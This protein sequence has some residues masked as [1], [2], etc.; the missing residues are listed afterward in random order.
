M[1]YTM[2]F[3]LFA[4][5]CSHKTERKLAS[6]N[7]LECPTGKKKSFYLEQVDGLLDDIRRTSWL[8]GKTKKAL[9][10]KKNGHSLKDGT[11]VYQLE[12]RVYQLGENRKDLNKL[13]NNCKKKLRTAK[14]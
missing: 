13:A 14:N 1:K 4:W 3:L 12:R 10:D 6:V 11:S 7:Q 8:L 9:E 5:S 2:I